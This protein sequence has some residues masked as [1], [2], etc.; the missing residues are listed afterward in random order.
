[1]KMYVCKCECRFFV[2]QSIRTKGDAPVSSE[3]PT[4]GEHPCFVQ[5]SL[6]CCTSGSL[7]SPA[8]STNPQCDQ[9][10]G[11]RYSA[12]AHWLFPK[13]LPQIE[14]NVWVLRYDHQFVTLVFQ[15]K[16]WKKW[17]GNLITF[18]TWI[19]RNDFF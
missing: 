6:S 7:C 8:R 17:F 13:L 11:G 5:E 18:E 10:Q 16:G 9:R 2:S 19:Q 4:R 15:K 14:M 12:E 3:K 1:M